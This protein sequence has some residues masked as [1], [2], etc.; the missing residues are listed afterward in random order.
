MVPQFKQAPTATRS[1]ESLT[2]AA[3]LVA[4]ARSRLDRLSPQEAV[5]AARAG[6]LLIDIRS[7]RQRAQDGAIP[8]ARIVDRNAFEW[9]CDPTSEWADPEVVK[10]IDRRLIVVCH[11]GYQSSLV[12]VILQRFG[13][14]RATDLVGGYLAWRAAG[15]PVAALSAV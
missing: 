3:T 7:D 10:D 5:E 9:R 4:E 12:A 14:A 1:G 15:L 8:G 13:F 6:A 2:N 11:E